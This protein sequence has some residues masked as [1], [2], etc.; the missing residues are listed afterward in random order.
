ML[1]AHVSH[2]KF[3]HS[4]SGFLLINFFLNATNKNAGSLKNKFH[5]FLKANYVI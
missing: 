3:N 2:H 5:H 1:N 4:F